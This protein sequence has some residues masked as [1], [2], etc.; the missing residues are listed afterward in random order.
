[1][2][3]TLSL[4]VF[5]KQYNLQAGYVL[6]FLLSLGAVIRFWDLTGHG[7]WLDELFSVNGA[8]PAH[9]LSEIIEYSKGD[10]PP[11]FFLFL[12][13][14][15]RAFGYSDFSGRA[16]TVVI[17]LLGIP[18][19]YVL[20]KEVKN[21][22]VGLMASFIT[23]INWFH[24]E[25]SREIR[26]YPLV[27]LLSTLSFLFFLRSVKRSRIHDFVFYAVFSGLLL[28]THYFGMVVFLAQSIIFFVIIFF[29]PRT[30]RLVIGGLLAGTVAALSIAHWIPI[31]LRDVQTDVFHV[32]PLSWSLPVTFVWVYFKDPIAGIIYSFSAFLML[33]YLLITIKHGRLPIE[34]VILVGW[35]LIGFLVPLLYSL[36]KIPLLTPKYSTIT[37]PAIFLFIACGFVQLKQTRIKVIAIFLLTIGGFV[38][39]AISRPIY[40]PAM[41]DDWREVASFFAK[42]SKQ[43]QT[44]FAQLA[45]FHKFYFQRF[46]YD[47]TLPIDQRW[48]D[49]KPIV[50]GSEKIWLFRHPR[51]PDNGFSPEQQE[52]VQ[53]DFFLDSVVHFKETKAFLYQRKKGQ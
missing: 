24:S 51:Y 19:I 27:F 41:S 37:L 1:M 39:L 47:Q 26:F 13:Q 20:G 35:L 11:L 8:D 33:R 48:A 21:S 3:G 50:S 43:P 6:L 42:H 30:L 34:D 23:T 36:I 49:F 32:A 15:L 10:Q 31:I 5:H 40:K 25:M 16:F 9:S 4:V 44:I 14:W 28:N 38:A 52:I 2:S 7:L 29:Y 46:G 18:A 45:Y 53:R 22:H 17:G 12:Q